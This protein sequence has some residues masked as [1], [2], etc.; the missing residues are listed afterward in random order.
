[1]MKFFPLII[2]NVMRNK[3]RT[4]FTGSSIAM[5][6]F[7]VVMLYSFLMVQDEIVEAS[8]GYHRIMVLNVQ[9]LTGN[10]PIAYVDRIRKIE[11]VHSAVPFSWYG[12]KYREENIP[13][14]QFATDA[15]YITDVLQEYKLPNDQLE[16]WR[17]DKTGCVVGALIAKNKNWKIGDKIPIRETSIPRIWN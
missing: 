9:G 8:K 14:A 3:V 17:A 2:R 10:L 7:L 11:E 16:A 1:M 15:Q 6:L 4:L 13:F 12:G 5:S